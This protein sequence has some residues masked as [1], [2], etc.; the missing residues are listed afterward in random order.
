MPILPYPRIWPNEATQL[1]KPNKEGTLPP[2]KKKKKNPKKNPWD[3]EFEEI[4]RVIENAWAERGI[5]RMLY[6]KEQSLG[7]V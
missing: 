1:Q 5:H 6:T 7:N 4:Y 2:Q 3:Q